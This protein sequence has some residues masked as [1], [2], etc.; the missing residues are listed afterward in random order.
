[1]R[2]R[3]PDHKVRKCGAVTVST[4]TGYVGVT[5]PQSRA[6]RLR[7]RYETDEGLGQENCRLSVVGG[8]IQHWVM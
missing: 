7:R 8:T 3:L 5:T 2:H 4:N 6:W 1:M